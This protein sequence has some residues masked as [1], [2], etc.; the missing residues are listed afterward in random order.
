MKP[1]EKR[2][3][4]DDL[5]EINERVETYQR[6]KEYLAA[7]KLEGG[8]AW[9]LTDEQIIMFIGREAYADC[10]MHEEPMLTRAGAYEVRAKLFN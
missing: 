1:Q 10:A 4:T 3:S 8:L 2:L 5:P 7:L 6:I 9:P